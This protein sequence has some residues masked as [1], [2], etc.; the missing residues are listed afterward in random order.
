MN[1]DIAELER[2]CSEATPGPWEIRANLPYAVDGLVVFSGRFEHNVT[3]GRWFDGSQN[4][5]ANVAWI[6]AAHNAWPALRERLEQTE[7]DLATAR[8]QAQTLREMLD[9]FIDDEPCTFDHHGYCQTHFSGATPCYMAEARAY[10][11]M[12]PQAREATEQ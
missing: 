2:L 10:L 5:R 6:V 7:A 3:V 8:A 1:L 12:V 4:M 11:A 9:G